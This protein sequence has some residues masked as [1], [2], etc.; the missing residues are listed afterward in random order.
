M[1]YH[2]D[3]ALRKARGRDGAIWGGVIEAKA[4]ESLEKQLSKGS[5]AT[6]IERVLM[7]KFEIKLA[8]LCSL[9]ERHFILVLLPSLRSLVSRCVWNR[10]SI[11]SPSALSGKSCRKSSI[12]SCDVGNVGRGLKSAMP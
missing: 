9:P 10:T 12:S 4:E 11:S 2:A 5:L 7:S 8:G 1:E 6:L 3:F